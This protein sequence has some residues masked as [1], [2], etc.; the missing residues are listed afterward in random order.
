MQLWLAASAALAF[1]IAGC[2]GGTSPNPRVAPTITSTPPS[3]A[4]VGVPYNYTVTVAGMTPMSFEVLSGPDGF[5]V[6]PTSGVVTW[7]P[8]AIGTE[9]VEIRATNLAGSDTQSFDVEVFGSNGPVFTTEPPLEATVAAPYAYDPMVVA[10]GAVTWTAPTAPDGLSIEESTGAVRWTPSS[11]QTGPQTVTIR[12]TEVEGG[13]STD[14]SF[15]VTVADTGGPAVITS[16]PP[17]MV[18]EG[19]LW[20]YAATAAGAPTIEWDVVAPSTGSP[21]LGVTIVDEPAE[22]PSA[23]IEWSTVGVLPGDYTVAIRVDNGL[24]EPD[25]Q[26]LVIRVEPRPPV[27]EIDLVTM[28]PPSTVFVGATYGYDVNLVPGSESPGVVFSLVGATTPEDLA[29]SVNPTTGEIGFTASEV[30]GEIEYAYTV[31][32]ENVLGEGDERTITVD[33]VL[34]PAEPMLVVTPDTSFELEVGASFAGASAIATGNPAPTLSIGGTLP[35]FLDF[36]ASTGLLSASST[37]P[38]PDVGDIGSYG[39]DIVAT[40]TEG[41]DSETIDIVV[42]AAAPGVDSIT[43]AAGRR[44]SDVPVVVRGTGFVAAASPTVRIERDGY[45]EDLPTSFVDENTLSALVP[46]NVSRPAGVYDVVVDQGSTTAL[47]KRF[48][49]TEGD[50]S[51][52]GGSIASDLT[53]SAAASPHVVT[54][55]VRIEGGATVTVEPGAVVMFGPNSNLRIDV[56]TSGAGALVADGGEPNVGDQI[57]FTRF[58]EVGGSAP[59]GHYRGLRFGANNVSSVTHLRNVVVEFGG[60]RNSATD[61]GAIEVSSGSAPIMTDMIVRE[62][63]N[64]GVYAQAGAGTDSVTWFDRNQ[65]SSNARG[66]INI[67]SDDIAT[68]GVNLDMIGNGVDRVFVRGSSVTRAMSAWTNYGIPFFVSAGLTIRGGATLSLEPGTELRFGQSTRLRVSI[69][70]SGMELGTLVATGTPESPIRMVA[71][72]NPWNGVYIDDDAQGGT[73]LRHVRIEGFGSSSNGGVRVDPST[74]VA[75]I[76]NC[77]VRTST[78]GSTGVYAQGGAEIQSFENNVIDVQGTSVNAPFRVFHDFL[79]ASNRYETPLRV[80]AGLAEGSIAWA[81]PTATDGTTQVIRPDG[82]LTVDEGIFSIAAG[83]RIEMPLN[84]QLSVID[85]QLLIGGTESEPV[86]FEPVAGAD[87]WHRIRLRGAG[88]TGPSA[89]SNAV[90]MAVGGSPSQGPSSSRAGIVL[91]TNSGSPALAS[92]RDTMILDSNGYGMSFADGTHCEGGCTGNTITGARFSAVRIAANFVGRLGAPNALSGNNTTNTLGHE[93]VWVTGD[94]VDTS[95]VWPSNGVPYVVHGDVEVRQSHPFA[96]IPV[97]TVEPGTELRFAEGRRLRVGEGNDATLDARGSAEAPI[98]FT[99]L[100]TTTPTFWDGIDFNQGSD[101]SVLDHVVVS[102]G[103]ERSGTGNVNFRIGS[104]VTIGTVTFSLSEEY[105]ARIDTGSAPMFMGAPA[106]RVYELNGQ[107][108]IP[109]SGDPA[110]DCVRNIGTGTC[111]AL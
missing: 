27:P 32:A 46:T 67:G 50:G 94:V 30:N 43:P 53:L 60:R 110:F 58:Q 82:N 98:V 56:G 29:V 9:S 102:Y 57:V 55:N 38:A 10:D 78:S 35:D 63:L 97:M 62:S 83:V 66:P 100:D 87:Y 103:G 39:F 80:R 81:K 19:E 64:Y 72:A 11:D 12:A 104:V 40:N 91:E 5:E 105:G 99:S 2:G 49:V 21:A 106:A 26:E 4:T 77:L 33:A 22:G 42:V 18:Y 75:I 28:P 6:H 69:P 61:Q 71:D 73:V 7:T 76:E 101:G 86:V 23:T 37:K 108:S 54:G 95:A 111:D 92:I 68:L 34:A 93:G 16:M 17:G 52:I 8:S 44:Q 47:T 15:V 31:R 13:L 1:S 109:G 20:T 96:P 25:V 41:M 89:V 85:S 65:L 45:E 84:G 90:L 70:G 107:A 14:Q 79:S 3:T 88:M 59:S 36:D 48:T 51:T 24:G 74:K